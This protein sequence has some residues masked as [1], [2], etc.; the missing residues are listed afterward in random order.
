MTKLTNLNTNH[1]TDQEVYDEEDEIIEHPSD[2]IGGFGPM[3]RTII[4]W[5][6]VCFMVA[7]FNNHHIVF[8]APKA[9][10][11]CVDTDPRTNLQ[12]NLTNSCKI[13]NQSDSPV[14][15]KFGCSVSIGPYT[16]YNVILR[17]IS[18]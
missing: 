3:Q 5:L 2:V 12:V 4:I 1:D 9:D 16:L 15:T 10:F 6:I 11:Y 7:P 14:C 18:H 13:G 17:R 8:T